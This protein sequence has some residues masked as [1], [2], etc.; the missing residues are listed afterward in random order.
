MA[1]GRVDR[2][3]KKLVNC[4]SFCQVAATAGKKDQT[5]QGKQ[6]TLTKLRAY[7]DISTC[8]GQLLRQLLTLLLIM[9][10]LIFRFL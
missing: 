8:F 3:G 1:N 10:L 4:L 9:Q 2:S 6:A 5:Q 7:F